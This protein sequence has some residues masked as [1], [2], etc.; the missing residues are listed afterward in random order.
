MATT[1]NN[2]QTTNASMIVGIVIVIIVL[3]ILRLP[4][5]YQREFFLAPQYI[6]QGAIAF[7]QDI[8]SGSI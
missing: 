4:Q 1:G 8:L 5:P 2:N 6:I 3:C 7:F